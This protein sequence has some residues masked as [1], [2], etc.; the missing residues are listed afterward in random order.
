MYWV[1]A[2][3]YPSYEKSAILITGQ[4]TQKMP[5]LE[6][7]PVHAVHSRTG[8]RASLKPHM[9]ISST[10]LS[11]LASCDTYLQIKLFIS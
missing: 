5:L 11:V 6:L 10:T 1:P 4:S 8:L 7:Q 3:W 9:T 2:V